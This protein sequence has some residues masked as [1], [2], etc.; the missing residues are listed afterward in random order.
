MHILCI[1]MYAGCHMGIGGVRGERAVRRP[2]CTRRPL[3]L[4]ARAHAHVRAKARL[5]P[6]PLRPFPLRPF[7]LRPFESRFVYA[8]AWARRRRFVPFR[9]FVWLCVCVGAIGVRFVCLFSPLSFKELLADAC[10][11]CF[12]PK[13]PATLPSERAWGKIGKADLRSSM[14]STPAHP[15]RRSP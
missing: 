10:C 9:S 13:E 1:H 6:F 12:L 3:R 4:R 14:R 8:C 5:R 7:P 11:C 2:A 15:Y